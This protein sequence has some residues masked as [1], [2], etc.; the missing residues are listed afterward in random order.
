MVRYR[1]WFWCSRC[2]WTLQSVFQ[3]C[4]QTVCLASHRNN[5]RPHQIGCERWLD[6]F[7]PGSH[8]FGEI[9]SLP[10]TLWKTYILKR[11]SP[12]RSTVDVILYRYSTQST[13][14]T[15]SRHG[16][17]PVYHETENGQQLFSEDAYPTWYSDQLVSRHALATYQTYRK[18]VL[19]EF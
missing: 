8:Y 9:S 13:G 10:K 16:T 14:A 5:A 19:R 7:R 17:T 18:I 3:L 2:I 12:H 15:I 11:F 6:L 4:R 1:C